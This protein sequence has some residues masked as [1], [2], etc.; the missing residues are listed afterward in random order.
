MALTAKQ[1]AFINEYLID[2]NATQAAIRAGYSPKTAK[3]IGYENLT[4]PYIAKIIEKA[5]QERSAAT[6]I[7][8]SYVLNGLRSIAEREGIKEADTIRAFELLGKHLKLFTENVNLS[9]SMAVQIL[10]DVE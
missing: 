5:M 3:L 7:T 10:D 6:G 4:K 2:L 8:A 9:G 1:Q